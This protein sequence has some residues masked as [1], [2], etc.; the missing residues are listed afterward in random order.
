M[1]TDILKLIPEKYLP[2]T[3]IEGIVRKVATSYI[4]RDLIACPE[5]SKVWR[6]FNNTIT[7][8][9]L[10]PAKH[11]EQF[12][13]DPEGYAG[14]FSHHI[15]TLITEHRTR[16]DLKHRR[17]RL[18]DREGSPFFPIFLYDEE[19][20][21]RTT[22]KGLFRGP[23]L[24]KVGFTPPSKVTADGNSQ[25]YRYIFLG[26]SESHTVG[27]KKGKKRGNAAIHGMHAVK[28]STICYAVIQVTP[29]I[30][31]PDPPS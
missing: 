15:H 16:K 31:A 21:D 10:C 20:M 3:V 14:C 25:A 29:R 19:L 23:L 5:T 30:T 11:I 13:R 22:T 28:P 2:D 8:R 1:K 4:D 18:V 17:L 7:A 9:L 12:K 6:G 27:T 26:P 24:V